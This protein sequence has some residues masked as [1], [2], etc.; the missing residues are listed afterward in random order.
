[1]NQVKESISKAPSGRVRRNPLARR[2][3]LTVVGKEDGYEYR[4]VNDK[5]DRVAEFTSQGYEIVS[6]SKVQVGDKRVNK[7][8]PEGS[9]MQMSVGGGQKALVMRIRKDWYDED[10]KAKQDYV[11]ETE[12]TTKQKALEG[13]YGKFE[14]SR[15]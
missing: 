10:Q 3:V 11:A 5:E 15:D 6:A 9:P 7:A 12:R 4:I 1:M 14:A 8:S 13:T 2:N